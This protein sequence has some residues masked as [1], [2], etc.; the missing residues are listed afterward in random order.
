MTRIRLPALLA[1]SI[2]ALLAG[3]GADTTESSVPDRG[4]APSPTPISLVALRSEVHHL[5]PLFVENR[6]EALVSRQIYDPLVAHLAPPL[7]ASGGR[8]GPARPIGPEQ[9]GRLWRFQLRPDARFQDG[10]DIDAEAVGANV[11]RWLT[12]GIAAQLLPELNAVDSPLPGEVRFQLSSPVPDL[13]R[14][15]SD[16]RLGLVSPTVLLDSGLGEVADGAGGSGAYEPRLITSDRVLLSASGDWW[17]RAAGLGPG[18]ARF[19]FT[20]APSPL[21]RLGLLRDGVV[22]IAED[23]STHAQSLLARDPLLTSVEQDGRVTGASAA[24]RGLH[25]GVPVQ[26][27]SETWLTTLR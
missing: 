4:D 24:V 8:R 23:L 25:G 27:L 1:V 9:G 17:G 20:V 19:E 21:Q 16:P 26:P 22:E 12:S 3:C 11:Q 10:T 2:L 5:D 13:P 14:R 18:I 15:L 6:S 7:G